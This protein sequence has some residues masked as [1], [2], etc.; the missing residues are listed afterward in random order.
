MSEVI[1]CPRCGKPMFL[2]H[3]DD[4]FTKW[5]RCS[6]CETT[7][8]IAATSEERVRLIEQTKEMRHRQH[9]DKPKIRNRCGG[10]VAFH[11]PFC[12]FAYT[13][14]PDLTASPSDYACTRFYPKLTD[15]TRSQ[16]M[17]FSQKVENL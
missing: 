16:R 5:Y 2:G 1:S 12:S 8:P 6:T 17:S 14:E 11:T 7:K 9:E 3:I 15:R 10:C 13:D 4:V